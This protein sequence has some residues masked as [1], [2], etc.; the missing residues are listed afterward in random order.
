MI[1]SKR[2]FKPISI[3][4]LASALNNAACTDDDVEVFD[5]CEV[6]TATSAKLQLNK[7]GLDALERQ[8]LWRQGPYFVWSTSPAGS[9]AANP[10]TPKDAITPDVA[11]RITYPLANQA[12]LTG[13]RNIAPGS[14][15]I[16]VFSH[17]NNDSVCNIFE[18]YQSLHEHWA[19]WGFVVVSV[20]DTE[21]N[22]KRGNKENIDLRSNRQRSAIQ[23]LEAL[24]QDPQSVFYQAI[25]ASKII[26]AGHSRGG[27]ASLVSWQKYTTQEHIKGIIDLQGIDMTSFGFGRPDINVPVIG[28]SASKDVDLNYPYVEP[29]EEQLRAPYT[30]VTL[31]GGIHAYTAD[32]VPIEPDDEPGIPQQVQQDLT[33]YFTTAFLAQH[34]GLGSA[35]HQSALAPGSATSILYSHQGAQVAAERLSKQGVA[36]RWNTKSPE[37]VILDDFEAARSAQPDLSVNLL[38]GQNICADLATCDEV[39]TYEPD[40]SSPSPMY[41]KASSRRLIAQETPFNAGIFSMTLPEPISLTPTARLQARIKGLDQAPDTKLLVHLYTDSPTPALSVN[42]QDHMGPI[43]MTNRYVQLDLPLE[44]LANA[45]LTQIAFEVVSGGVFIDDPRIEP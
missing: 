28:I 45:Q 2:L 23:A 15:P 38:G 36:V 1:M 11:L 30:W 10:T 18:R 35:Q 9:C 41:A 19:S 43:P 27:G 4:L 12:R 22:C 6:T 14:W 37:A 8:E 44:E 3:I 20:D 26:L 17:A 32:T 40:K 16:I 13:Q 25:D 34:L 29:T 21:L 42:A 5:P 33:E 39:S 24:N 31:Y 7:A